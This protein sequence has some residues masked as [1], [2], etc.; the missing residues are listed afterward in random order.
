MMGMSDTPIQTTTPVP[1]SEVRKTIEGLLESAIAGTESTIRTR[2]Y[3]G[4]RKFA[5]T[6]EEW[7]E[8]Y[9]AALAWLNAVRE[10]TP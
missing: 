4:L 1:S 5:T 6:E 3:H 2:D 7:I 10:T 8:R 9:K